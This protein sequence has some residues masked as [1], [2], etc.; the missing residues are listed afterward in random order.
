MAAISHTALLSRGVLV[1]DA[2]SLGSRVANHGTLFG[3][4][5]LSVSTSYSGP[6]RL[7]SSFV[8]RA[9]ADVYAPIV[10]GPVEEPTV[11]PVTTLAIQT[12]ADLER[13]EERRQKGIKKKLKRRGMWPP[14]K[15]IKNNRQCSKYKAMM[16]RQKKKAALKA[17]AIKKAKAEA[18]E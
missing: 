17:E 9:T 2:N 12:E 11:M 18:V 13:E 10:E 6:V 15:V 5:R 4:S 14:S 8:A 1:A 3:G 7:A 16:K